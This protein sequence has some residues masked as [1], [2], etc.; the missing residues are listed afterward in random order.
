M[1]VWADEALA[2]APIAK[3]ENLWYN[4]PLM[5]ANIHPN[6]QECTVTCACGNS[7]VTRATVATMQVDICDKCH[8]F[9]TG[10]ER[11]VDKQGRIDKFKQKMD[12]SKKKRE[13][14]KA[15]EAERLAKK[16]E[17][18]A[19]TAEKKSFK[20]ILNQ[21]KREQEVAEKAKKVEAKEA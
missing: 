19:P 6:W 13:E 20:Q 15:K 5:K 3:S 10:E 21:A 14:Q 16:A 9:F 2:F 4:R 17:A 11:F 12:I 18:A 7:F 1:C 8:P